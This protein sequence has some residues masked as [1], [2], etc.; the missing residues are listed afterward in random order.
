MDL[1]FKIFLTRQNLL[2]FM[3]FQDC[4]NK[5]KKL[6]HLLSWITSLRFKS[7]NPQFWKYMTEI[8]CIK[9]FENYVVKKI[10]NYW[11]W[12]VLQKWDYNT[13]NTSTK[14]S[15]N[16]SKKSENFQ[17]RWTK[18]EKPDDCSNE[19]KLDSSSEKLVD[20]KFTRIQLI[21][22]TKIKF[23]TKFDQMNIAPKQ[24]TFN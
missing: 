16:S 15:E 8:S 18:F 13:L 21:L 14:N 23:S 24:K 1:G 9:N 6:N 4:T 7:A 3:D 11:L 17:I 22:P 20:N 10:S 5:S 2:F 19:I 12:S